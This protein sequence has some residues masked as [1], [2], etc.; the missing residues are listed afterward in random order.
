[1]TE[2]KIRSMYF[3]IYPDGDLSTKKGEEDFCD[4]VRVLNKYADTIIE[5]TA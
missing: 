5:V 4:L 3:D 1:M 2:E